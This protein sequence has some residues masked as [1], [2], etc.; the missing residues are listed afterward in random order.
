MEGALYDNAREMMT[1]LK[2]T[3]IL[4]P[5]PIP[6]LVL[7][8]EDE[9]DDQALASQMVCPRLIREDG[10]TL[11]KDEPKILTDT[12]PVAGELVRFNE[13]NVGTE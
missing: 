10:D 2:S 12:A 9:S 4:C 5:D 8:K 1:A 7:Q 3:S 13:L 11:P 6:E